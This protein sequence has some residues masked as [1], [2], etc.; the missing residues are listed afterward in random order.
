MGIA[1]PDNE[2]PTITKSSVA[3]NNDLTLFSQTKEHKAEPDSA[4][5]SQIV[6]QER[7]GRK[8]IAVEDLNEKVKFAPVPHKEV[9]FPDKTDKT[10]EPR[11]SL[12]KPVASRQKAPIP[13]LLL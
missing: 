7:N 13:K 12:F 6:N 2:Y 4:T 5:L 3:R 11:D 9:A 1:E 8:I 10:V